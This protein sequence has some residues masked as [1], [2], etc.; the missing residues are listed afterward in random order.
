MVP[1][2][3]NILFDVPFE[4]RWLKA[5]NDLGVDVAKLAY[6]GGHA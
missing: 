2:N 5:M 3:A 4:Q 6:M 1:A